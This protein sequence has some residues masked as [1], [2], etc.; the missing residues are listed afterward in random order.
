MTGSDEA[1]PRGRARLLTGLFAFLLTLLVGGVGGAVLVSGFKASVEETARR[2]VTVI[3]GS[4]ARALAMQFEKAARF[5]IP[6]K[7]IPG[8]E[9]YLAQ[10][11]NQTPGIARIVVRGPDGREVRS[12]IGPLAGTDTVSAPIAVD[13]LALGQVDVTTSPLAFSGTFAALTLQV[14]GAVLAFAAVAGIASGLVA[15]GALERRRQRLAAAMA[16]NVA[17]ELDGGPQSAAIGRSPV[18]QAFEAL[19][20]GAR[21]VGDKWAAFQAYAE[22][23]LAVDFDGRLRP[24]VE[25]IRREALPRGSQ[26]ERGS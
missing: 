6:L 4:L 22:E 26:S 9:G 20:R 15:G 5:G 14:A 24:E 19:S 11:L 25:R 23:L 16:H 21:R 2:D 7:L 13:G 1:L 18:A 17:G 12:A 3:G 8:V 10:T